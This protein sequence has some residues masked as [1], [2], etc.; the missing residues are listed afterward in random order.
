LEPRIG[1]G[2][3]SCLR[4]LALMCFNVGGG[5]ERGPVDQITALSGSIK[6]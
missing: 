6:G 4:D 5:L 3:R 2:W 1:D